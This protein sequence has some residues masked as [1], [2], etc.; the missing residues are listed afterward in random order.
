MCINFSLVYLIRLCFL[1]IYLL[2]SGADFLSLYPDRTKQY[3]STAY[4]QSSDCRY[5]YRFSG[6]SPKSEKAGDMMTPA[7]KISNYLFEFSNDALI[8]SRNSG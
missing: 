3:K 4:Y 7:S 1:I 6:F 2:I 8:K 5:E